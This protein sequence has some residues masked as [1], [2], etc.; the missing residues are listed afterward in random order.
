MNTVIIK[1]YRMIKV[2]EELEHS[3][4]ISSNDEKMDARAVE[5]VRTAIN[6]A[7]FC[8][9]PIAIYDPQTKR[10]YVAYADGK[11]KYID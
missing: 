10:V 8:Q 5:A 1:P 11:R 2:V 6:K 7:K 9:K 3:K 4:Y